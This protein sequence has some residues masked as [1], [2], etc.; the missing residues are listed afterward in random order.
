[1]KSVIFS[2]KGMSCVVCS[3]SCQKALLKLD[4]VRRAD[5]NFASGK[6]VVE[7]DEKK[8]DEQALAAAISKAGYGAEFGKPSKVG[9]KVDTDLVFAVIRIV[10]GA[11]LLLWAML[12]M[13]GV[14][15]PDAIS[16]DGNPFVFALVQI[17]LCVPVL[18]VSWKI[19]VRGY[20]NLFRLDPNMDSLVAVSTTAAFAYSVYGFV[21]VCN[22]D[23]HA[24]HNLYFESAA[25]ILALISLG[26]YLEHRALART[27]EAIS[28][29]TM[30][31]PKEAYVERNGEFVRIDASDI[32]VG[33]LVMVR[34]GE[35]FC[36]DGIVEE[37][38]SAVQESMLTGESLPVDK[39]PGDKVIGGTVNGDGT[40]KFRATGVGGDT[41]LS[42][43]IRLVENAQ[44]SKAPI[45]RLADKVSKIFVPSVMAIAVIAAVI[46]A[47]AGGEDSAFVIKVFV[48]VLTIACPCA[49]GLATP[50]AIITGSGAG[51]K[52]GILY[53][54]AE[55]LERCAHIDTVVLD[56]T[57]TVT[58]GIPKVR[59]VFAADGDEKS[60]LSLIAAAERQS[61]HPLAKAVADHADEQ[62]APRIEAESAENVSGYGV[63]AVLNGKV[64]LCGKQA[65]LEKEGA[66]VAPIREA[67]DEAYSMGASVV[68][69][70]YDGKAV[71][72]VALAD[73]LRSGAKELISDLHSQNVKTVMLTG[74]NSATARAI[75]SEAGIDEA[76]SEV[77]PGDKAEKVRSLMDSGKKVAMVGDGINDA[78]ALTQAD[79]GI[80]I[81]E[82]SDIAVESADVV[83]VG[84]DVG[85]AAY[86]LEL[87]RATVRNIKENLF[88]AFIY[89]ILGIPFAAGAVYALGG[90]LLDPM[91]AALAMSLSSVSV[92]LN[93]LRL[94]AFKPKRLK[95]KEK[96]NIIDGGGREGTAACPAG[97]GP[98]SC[99]CEVKED[100]MKT[101]TVKVEGMMCAHCE[102]H[103]S[104]AIKAIPGV[105]DCKADKDA[106]TATVTAE[107]E[108][109]L[110][111][112]KKAVE[113]AGYEVKD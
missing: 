112:L 80:A 59:K 45:A 41:M 86:A 9:V 47:T 92:V 56:K 50:T 40:L 66:D 94:S 15:Y 84:G 19:Y 97:A 17:V 60:L 89:N 71:G 111:L 8:V 109:D 4:G 48:S 52:I 101:F 3:A 110:A 37:G 64:L 76:I 107:K 88:W 46:W 63:K 105:T 81:G 27:G 20:R 54:N 95:N 93:A 113:D 21:L 55:A 106:K 108:I 2:I 24:V 73:G 70:A 82:G 100:E 44:N 25:V 18:A 5:V 99:P 11:A 51:A 7:Y 65:F 78:P 90:P 16:P 34:A 6:A 1:M 98:V 14:P 68:A 35:S 31:A 103:V 49:L 79:V 32:V 74:D 75:A 104:D 53:K 30:L 23:A 10:L 42:K 85:G 12:P 33:D 87:G 91:I 39:G 13:I 29:L 96:N 62:G 102:K 36:C 28:K 77:L 43:I 57:G 69:A 26:K 58:E 83:L 61:S 67:L 72:V 38:E 22:G